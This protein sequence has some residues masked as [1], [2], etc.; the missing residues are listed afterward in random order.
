MGEETIS[1]T[2]A[3]AEMLDRRAKAETFYQPPRSSAGNGSPAIAHGSE[4]A[5]RRQGAGAPSST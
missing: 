1:F 4:A 3:R 5:S 2:M